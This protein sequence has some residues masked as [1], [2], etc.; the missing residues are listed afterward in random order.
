MIYGPEWTDKMCN[1][2]CDLIDDLH[3]NHDYDKNFGEHNC[4]PGHGYWYVITLLELL[5][6]HPDHKCWADLHFKYMLP[7]IASANSRRAAKGVRHA[8]N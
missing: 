1:A 8:Q 5:R 3:D 4:S 7:R 6:Q 2:I